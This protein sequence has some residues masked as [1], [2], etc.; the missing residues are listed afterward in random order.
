MPGWLKNNWTV[1]VAFVALTSL[2]ILA[3][4]NRW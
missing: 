2:W 4:Q 1:G 3:I